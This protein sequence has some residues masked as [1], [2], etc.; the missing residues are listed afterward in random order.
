MFTQVGEVSWVNP[1]PILPGDPAVRPQNVTNLENV[2]SISP[3]VWFSSYRSISV[4]SPFWLHLSL[5]LNLSSHLLLLLPLTLPLYPHLAFCLYTCRRVTLLPTVFTS[6]G[7][8]LFL[9][10]LVSPPRPGPGH[11]PESAPPVPDDPC[12]GGLLL[13]L[14]APGLN[15]PQFHCLRLWTLAGQRHGESGQDTGWW[16]GHLAG[17]LLPQATPQFL[18]RSFPVGPGRHILANT[19]YTTSGNT[20]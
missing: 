7:F 6:C 16:A 5:S 17:L 11:P 15:A 19:V 20:A 13:R 10:V 1:Q 18:R 9:S 12:H 2:L 4:S 8:S 3:L 14:H